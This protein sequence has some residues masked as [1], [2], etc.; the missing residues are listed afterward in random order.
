MILQE[1]K[2]E[3]VGAFDVLCR[4]SSMKPARNALVS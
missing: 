3:D 2:G 1:L 4:A